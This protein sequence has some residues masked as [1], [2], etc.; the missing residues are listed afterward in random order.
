MD[1]RVLAAAENDAR[2]CDLV[3]R[4]HGISTATQ[5]GHWVALRRPPAVFPDAVTLLPSAT[6]ADVLRSAQDDSGCSVR[7]SF[8]ALDLASLGFD[9]LSEAQWLFR[10]PALPTV[11]AAALWSDVETGE[12]LAEWAQAAGA[13][14]TYRRELLGEASVRFLALRGKDGLRAGAVATW[15]ASVVGVTIVFTRKLTAHEAWKGL[16]T[17]VAG[18]FPAVPLVCRAQ[19]E[20]RK[21]ALAHGFVE[22]GPLRV[23]RRP[24]E[25]AASQSPGAG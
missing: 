14:D 9:E 4:A 3:C 19:G 15:S 20:G 10:A 1:E 16:A 13:S 6:A 11:T 5:P 21:A 24:V 12:E 25:G 7:D 17:A 23:W 18:H 22:T 8:A 2:W